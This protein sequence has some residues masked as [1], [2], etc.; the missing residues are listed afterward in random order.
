MKRRFL[1]GLMACTLMAAPA[2]AQ[3]FVDSEG[4]LSDEDFYRLVACAAPPGEDCQKPMVHWQQS[5]PLRV[6]LREIDDAYLG[7]KKL[8]AKAALTRA[9]Q[10][11]NGADIG[12]RLAEVGP[13]D[14]AEIQIY[15]LDLERGDKITG[16]GIKGVDGSTLGGASTRVLFDADKG[17]IL[18]AAIVFSTTLDLKSYESVMLEELAQGLGLMTDIRN[19]YYDDK[20]IFS[21]DSNA[22]KELGVQDISA[23]KTHYQRK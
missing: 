11:I 21:Q 2:R 6:S 1:I 18:K 12:V 23:L 22:L 8:R 13:E 14:T 4:A 16:T 10:A 17:A 7:A 15:F 3:E 9:L 5:R 20:S 19:P